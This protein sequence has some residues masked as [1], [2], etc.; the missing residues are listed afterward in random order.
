MNKGTY[1]TSPPLLLAYAL[2]GNVLVDLEQDQIGSNDNQVSI[3]DLWPSRQEVEQVEDEIVL[4]RLFNQIEE[5][6]LV[7]DFAFL[8]VANSEMNIMF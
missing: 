6:M 5:N 8:C 3:R 7:R 4:K 1:V 2:A